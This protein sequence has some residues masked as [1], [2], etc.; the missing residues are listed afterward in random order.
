MGMSYQLLWVRE[1]LKILFFGRGCSTFSEAMS[2]WGWSAVMSWSVVISPLLL[3]FAR[4]LC[5]DKND[6]RC[7]GKRSFIVQ[8]CQLSSYEISVECLTD[9][10]AFVRER[11]QRN[12]FEVYELE[13]F[14]LEEFGFIDPRGRG[15]G[16]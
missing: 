1:T 16:F 5:R 9:H 8:L 4:D 3:S 10:D 7:R 6:S 13:R 14:C 15:V 12:C 2:I 11:E